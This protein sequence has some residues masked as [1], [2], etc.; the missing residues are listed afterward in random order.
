[1][2]KLNTKI[3]LDITNQKIDFGKFIIISAEQ[4]NANRCKAYDYIL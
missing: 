3:K 2:K 4:V 1:M